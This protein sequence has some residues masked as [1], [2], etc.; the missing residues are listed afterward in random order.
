M[1]G[2]F[3]L[4]VLGHG[5]VLAVLVLD[6]LG[7][8]PPA[9]AEAVGVGGIEVSFAAAGSAPG[10]A[11]DTVKP[12]EQIET[13]EAVE[14]PVETVTPVNEV[15]AAVPPEEVKPVEE[16][17]PAA[18][19]ATEVVRAEPMPPPPPKPRPKPPVERRTV[20]PEQP[21]AQVAQAPAERHTPDGEPTSA[22][23]IAGAAGRSG[24]RDLTGPGAAVS[25]AAGGGIPGPTPS[26]LAELR[27]WLERHKQYPRRAQLRHQQGTALLRF[28]MDRSGRVLSYRVERSSG[29]SVLDAEV[30]AM[31]QRASPLPPLPDDIP[32]PQLEIVVPV[33]FRLR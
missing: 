14:T 18:E 11:V 3:A 29:H 2:A 27:A 22:P 21:P 10:A 31:I 5:A 9:T 4:S 26:Y 24:T 17:I 12:S 13:V 8:D 28:T 15:A 20:E 16:P 23:T 25:T 1:R 19:A 7:A 30:E 6:F 32:G 33:S